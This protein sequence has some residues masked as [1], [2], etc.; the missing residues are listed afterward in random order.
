M[1]SQQLHTTIFCVISHK[2]LWW[3][4]FNRVI[5]EVP[6]GFSILKSYDNDIDARRVCNNSEKAMNHD[7]S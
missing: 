6:V 1:C 7:H 2:M 4:K 5:E 3:E